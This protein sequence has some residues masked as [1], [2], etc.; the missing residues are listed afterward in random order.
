ML[1]KYLLLS[2]VALAL[3]TCVDQTNTA[4]VITLNGDNPHMVVFKG[5]YVEP[6]AT[7]VDAD[8]GPLEVVIDA[9]SVDTTQAGASFNVIYSAVDSDAVVTTA[10][11]AV[12]IGDNQ[13]PTLTL[14]GDAS[15]TITV[16]EDFAAA[17]P[18]A[19]AV[20]TEDGALVVTADYSGLDSAIAGSYSVSYSA[21]D[22]EG[23][24]A[25]VQRTVVVID[26]TLSAS[27]VA[28]RLS[29]PA[30]LAVFFDATDT[31]DSD[32]VEG[33]H[34]RELGY[35][36]DFDD[37]SSGVWAESGLSKNSET[38]APLAAHVFEQPGVYRV[39]VRAR[40]SAGQVADAW[41]DITVTDADTV[42][43][44]TNTVVISMGG[45]FTGAPA[46][47]EQ[48]SFAS[49]WPSFQSN[50][51]YL[52]KSGDDFTALG[53]LTIRDRSNFQLASFGAGAKPIVSQVFIDQHKNN[54]ATPPV[55]GVVQGLAMSHFEQSKMFNHLLIYQNDVIG[56]GARIAFSSA[57]TYFAANDRGT[58]Q[59]SDWKHPGPVF[60]VENHVN[61]QG[62]PF[63][64]LNAISGLAHHVAI[65][66]NI[67]EQ[68]KEHSVRLFGTYKSVIA[69]NR[70]TGPATDGLRHDLKLMANGIN[71]WPEDNAIFQAGT[72]TQLLP[73]TRYVKI[74]NNI[75]GRPSAPHIWHIQVAPQDDGASGTVEGLRD[76]IIEGNQFIDGTADN[77][78]ERAIQTMG[79]RI[80]ERGNTIPPTWTQPVQTTEYPSGYSA[81]NPL[82]DDWHGPYHINDPVPP[83]EPPAR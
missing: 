3:T 47:A 14:N 37:P 69:H 16:G 80:T 21:Q 52:L 39:G 30:P 20:D 83:T 51:R 60:L 13:L 19:T 10:V 61:M 57:N 73:N 6:G 71:P 53:M 27:L 63:G 58:S 66:G 54:A 29:G 41:V 50:K 82:Y 64:P 77:G 31:V 70:M 12:Q 7:A 33:D 40:N 55:N 28:S 4:P 34:F 43:A 72:L 65:L 8:D 74:S 45:D 68:A 78:L 38:G 17:D 62:Y 67:S 79:V 26:P 32:S 24:V 22:A 46:G 44:G 2:F 25:A 81:S 35:Y 42:Y 48:I 59:P 9:S 11:R 36:F 23:Q 15:V 56:D 1:L 75:V 49:A 18:G 5:T 76:I